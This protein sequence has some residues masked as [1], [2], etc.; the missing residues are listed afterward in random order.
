MSILLLILFLFFIISSHFLRFFKD[1]CQLYISF[2][3]VKAFIE[4]H[5]QWICCEIRVRVCSKS[6]LN[7]RV[8]LDVQ[9]TW[10]IPRMSHWHHRSSQVITRTR[11]TPPMGNKPVC[12]EIADKMNRTCIRLSAMFLLCTQTSA[13]PVAPP[14]KQNRVICKKS[15]P[16][17]PPWEIPSVSLIM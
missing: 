5:P 12:L 11:V 4:A 13:R 2:I 16:G 6:I 7:G 3:L 8:A 17:L 1:S 15:K 14:R 9:R 10:W